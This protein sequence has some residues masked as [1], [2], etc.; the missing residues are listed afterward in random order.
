M[1]C[2]TPPL[3][4]KTKGEQNIAMIRE[5]HVYGN[6]RTIE[7]WNDRMIEKDTVQHKGLGKQLMEVVEKIAKDSEYEKIA[8]ISGVGVRGYYRKL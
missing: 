7:T 1:L 3:Q 5:L 6:V 4:R 2:T 8:V